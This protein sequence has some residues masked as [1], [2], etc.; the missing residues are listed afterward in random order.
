[1]AAG[2][3]VACGLR[4]VLV[5]GGCTDASVVD[6]L[7]WR[8]HAAIAPPDVVVVDETSAEALADWVSAGRRVIVVSPEH[9]R[10]TVYAGGDGTHV[11]PLT[12]ELLVAAATSH[13]TEREHSQCRPT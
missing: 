6:R 5:E 8:D 2:E 4:D 3:V 7:T 10:M 1:M 13:P 12:E 11:G 9:A